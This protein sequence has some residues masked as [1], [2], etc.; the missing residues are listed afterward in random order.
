MKVTIVAI[1]VTRVFCLYWRN[2]SWKKY[3]KCEEPHFF[4]S[5]QKQ[6]KNWNKNVVIWNTRH[7]PCLQKNIVKIK[8]DLQVHDIIY[9]E[10]KLECSPKSLYVVVYDLLLL[11]GLKW[12]WFDRWHLKTILYQTIYVWLLCRLWR[13]SLLIKLFSFDSIGEKNLRLETICARL[14]AALAYQDQEKSIGFLECFF[15]SSLGWKDKKMV[16][17]TKVTSGNCLDICLYTNACML[18]GNLRA[19]SLQTCAGQISMLSKNGDGCFQ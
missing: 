19:A 18:F 6:K 1:S 5:L 13:R 7:F 17:G 2:V 14:Y 12:K 9:R 16:C 10:H 4:K 8:L 3:E 15:D 11:F